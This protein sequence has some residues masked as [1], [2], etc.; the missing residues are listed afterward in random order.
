M[1]EKLLV[2]PC[3]HQS[4]VIKVELHW[5]KQACRIK[6][7]GEQ[8]SPF[9]LCIGPIRHTCLVTKLQAQCTCVSQ[10]I[11]FTLTSWNIGQQSWDNHLESDISYMRFFIWHKQSIHLHNILSW[12]SVFSCINNYIKY[13]QFHQWMPNKASQMSATR[14]EKE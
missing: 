13:Q 11:F 6:I 12:V 10:G 1:V 5:Q 14:Q 7:P 9:L 3:F 2:L 8:I 4:Y